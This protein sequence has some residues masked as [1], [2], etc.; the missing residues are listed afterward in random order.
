MNVSLIKNY[1]AKLF[2][3]KS[4]QNKIVLQLK[5]WVSRKILV[6]I[7]LSLKIFFTFGL[8][9]ISHKYLKR[10]SIFIYLCEIKKKDSPSKIYILFPVWK[11]KKKEF[12]YLLLIK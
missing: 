4:L 6:K 10:K 2:D 1:L 8:P 5:F 12:C 11:I 7:Y 9:F 3:W